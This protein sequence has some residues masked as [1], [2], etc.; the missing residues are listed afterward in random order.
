[1]QHRLGGLL[2]M[3][4]LLAIARPALVE[5]A[6]AYDPGRA[7]FVPYLVQRLKWAMLDEAR[8]VRRGR[9]VAARAAACA[10][11]ERLADDAERQ[12]ETEQAPLRSEAEYQ[13]DLSRL[14]AER[15]AAMALGLTSV[16]VKARHEEGPDTPEQLYRREE[17]RRDI[18]A[19]VEGLPERQRAL[20]ER[21]YYADEKF[22]AIAADLG[23]S[24]SWA[25]RLHAQAIGTLAAALRK[26]Y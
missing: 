4:E 18:A 26:R 22:E 12:A 5:A 13:A 24:K 1:M 14:L 23:V 21:H 16:P 3:D 2:G 25:S 15:A 6:S 7:P 9:K 11:I 8:R 20:V 17:L 19:A 10:A